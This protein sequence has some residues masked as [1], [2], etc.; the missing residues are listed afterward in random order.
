MF[1]HK[2]IEGLEIVIEMGQKIQDMSPIQQRVFKMSMTDLIKNTHPVDN[3]IGDPSKYFTHKEYSDCARHIKKIVGSATTFYSD[4]PPEPLAADKIDPSEL[5]MPYPEMN[6]QFKE[7]DG[8]EVCFVCQR[9]AVAVIESCLKSTGIAPRII[10]YHV[11]KDSKGYYEISNTAIVFGVKDGQVHSYYDELLFAKGYLNTL[12]KTEVEVLEVGIARWATI[13]LGFIGFMN[14]SNVSQTTVSAPKKLNKKRRQKGRVELLSYKVLKV[15]HSNGVI[16]NMS[17]LLGNNNI[18]L[19]TRRGHFG[20]R[21]CGS[22]G[23]KK[24]IRTWIS[25][26]VVGNSK[27][28]VIRKDYTL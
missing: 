20:H 7:A 12:S 5:K 16:T 15:K 27:K 25:P 21:W 13:F 19:H 14:C 10:T 2:I 4:V 17:G 6:L 26:C 23:D 18:R 22:G 1:G 24:L 9:P 3:N 11:F 8:M 28:G